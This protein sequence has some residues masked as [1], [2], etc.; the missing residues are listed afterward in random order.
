MIWNHVNSNNYS[1]YMNMKKIPKKSR[2][3]LIIF[4]WFTK[5]LKTSYKC[6]ISHFSHSNVDI[7]YS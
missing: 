3:I 4:M 2:L 1:I 6:L 7:I 5:D